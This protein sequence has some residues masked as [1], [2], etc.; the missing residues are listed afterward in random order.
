MD[1][2]V[3]RQAVVQVVQEA[4]LFYR[5]SFNGDAY[6]FRGIGDPATLTVLFGEPRHKRAKANALDKPRYLNGEM[7][8]VDGNRV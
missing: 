1:F 8:F 6:A 7:M 5:Q 4:S 3:R 2:R